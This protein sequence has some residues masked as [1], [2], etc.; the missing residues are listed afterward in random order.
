MRIARHCLVL[1]TMPAAGF[2]Q[3]PQNG[4]QDRRLIAALETFVPEA[5]RWDGAPGLTI[6]VGRRG[7]LLWERGY[8]WA[9][10]AKRT[11]M[12]PATVTRAGSM[13]KTYTGTAVMQLVEAGVLGLDQPVNRY[14]RDFTVA[15]PLGDRDITVQDLLTHTSGL[16]E[17]DA[18][19]AD[20]A[21]MATVHDYLQSVFARAGDKGPDGKYLR[22][23]GRVGERSSYSNIGITLLGFLVEVTNPE[24]LSFRDYVLRH[25]QAPLGMRHTAFPP[26]RDEPPPPA[27][28]S[29][30]Y[31]QIG[32]ILLPVPR[33]WVPV[34]PA[35]TLFATASEHLR[36]IL[37]F[38]D[39]GRYEGHAIL[40]PAGATRMLTPTVP[41]ASGQLGL[42]WMLDHWGKPNAYFGHGGAYMFGWTNTGVGYPRSGV[43]AVITVN[44]WPMQTYGQARAENLIAEF[45][46]SWLAFDDANPSARWPAHPWAWKRSYGIGMVMAYSYHGMLQA[47]TRLSGPELDRLAAARLVRDQG[48]L[49]ER[50][51]ADGFRAGFEQIAPIAADPAAIQQ[52]LGSAALKIHPAELELVFADIGGRG[53]LPAP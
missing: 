27:A 19:Y 51:S 29:T 33:L 50:W 5:L 17:L 47:K 1:A 31:A 36:L 20:L 40:S 42:V 45:I 46:A 12:T 10:L 28:L 35:G 37:A 53:G 30:G 22:W 13:S 7:R 26:D 25:I 52:L 18:R 48:S 49:S 34:H 6:A 3:A 41:F 16:S 8:G 44:R 38:L 24:H 15:N 14:L 32:G 39:E 9:D 21:P 43:G 2:A 23:T 4:D 11:R